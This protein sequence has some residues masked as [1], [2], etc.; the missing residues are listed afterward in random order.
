LRHRARRPQAHRK[1]ESESEQTQARDPDTQRPVW[2]LPPSGACRRVSER[3]P[4]ADTC[5]ARFA[6]A[7][8][9]CLFA[10]E[11]PGGGGSPAQHSP[12][13]PDTAPALGL[14]AGATIFSW[15]RRPADPRNPFPF[16]LEETLMRAWQ[17]PQ[18]AAL[19]L[20][21]FF[22]GIAATAGAA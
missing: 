2:L 8:S 20:A 19:A 17:P 15:C 21:S 14:R 12:Q 3:P 4:Q 1:R 10:D 16:L 9:Y 5:P 11:A 7:D 13:R 18:L 6:S 22:L